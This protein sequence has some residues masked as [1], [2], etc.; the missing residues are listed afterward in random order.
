MEDVIEGDKTN[1]YFIQ[2]VVYSKSGLLSLWNTIGPSAQQV[3][4]KV[5]VVVKEQDK[6]PLKL[7]LMLEYN[8]SSFWINTI[9]GS[10]TILP[11]E[12]SERHKFTPPNISNI[13]E[14]PFPEINLYKNMKSNFF[15]RFG[16]TS[17]PEAWSIFNAR[18]K[19]IIY[20]ETAKEIDK[21]FDDFNRD[22]TL[23]INQ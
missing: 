17:N 1:I 20:I 19:E 21:I 6:I 23:P 11:K 14:D 15:V 5:L 7:R 18:T 8:G 4:K 22:G 3:V 12:F 16:G 9:N 10:E 13:G 2:E